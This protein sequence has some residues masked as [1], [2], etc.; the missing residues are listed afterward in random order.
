MGTITSALANAKKVLEGTGPSGK[1]SI[2]TRSGHTNFSA[3]VTHE[4]SH[5]PY[6]MVGAAKSALKKAVAPESEISKEARDA[7]EG[8]KYRMQQQH[9]LSQ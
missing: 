1:S 7:G 8:I 5:A 6:S 9:D 3:P 4:Y 2:A